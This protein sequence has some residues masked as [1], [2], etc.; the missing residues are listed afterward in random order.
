[1]R[2]LP[3]P[4]GLQDS[5]FKYRSQLDIITVLKSLWH[6]SVLTPNAVYPTSTKV[7]NDNT[8][9]KVR[10]ETKGCGSGRVPAGASASIL[11]SENSS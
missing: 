2:E 3:G 9:D 4:F 5:G 1:M 10:S 11:H 7:T 6:V 8:A